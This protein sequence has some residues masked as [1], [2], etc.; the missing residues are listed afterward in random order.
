MHSRVSFR[1]YVGRQYGRGLQTLRRSD[2]SQS[3][4]RPRVSRPRSAD[5]LRAAL[6][7]A[8]GP[9]KSLTG[10]PLTPHYFP[11]R[12]RRRT[13]CHRR[14]CGPVCEAIE[15]SRDLKFPGQFRLTC[16]TEDLEHYPVFVTV[17][18]VADSAGRLGRVKGSLR[19]SGFSDRV[20]PLTRP[21]PSLCPCHYRSDWHRDAECAAATICD[22]SRRRSAGR[23]VRECRARQRGRVRTIRRKNRSPGQEPHQVLGRLCALSS[24]SPLLRHEG[25]VVK[26]AQQAA[27]P[28]F[29][30]CDCG[31]P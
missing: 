17:A 25:K 31:H 4:E 11:P 1:A 19:R 16:T 27:I 28:C 23:S 21:A 5:A 8:D 10:A 30:E 6:T 7:R 9:A 12:L 20:A 29:P 2:I 13:C 15:R 3:R 18:P 14:N 22:A 24:A 26:G